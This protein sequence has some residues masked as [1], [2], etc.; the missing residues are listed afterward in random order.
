MSLQDNGQLY[1][2]VLWHG[3]AWSVMV[4]VDTFSA[5]LRVLTIYWILYY[6]CFIIKTNSGFVLILFFNA[7][8][9]ANPLPPRGTSPRSVDEIYL[10][11]TPKETFVTLYTIFRSSLHG[12][13]L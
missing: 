4:V 8:S 12:A 6:R 1:F 10:W 7:D 3:Q 9:K 5:L 13:H 2:H 11:T